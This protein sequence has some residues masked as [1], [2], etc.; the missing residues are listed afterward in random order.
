MKVLG[1]EQLQ[2]IKTINKGA[3]AIESLLK[4]IKP[5]GETSKAI[6]ALEA[7]RA[8]FTG[9]WKTFTFLMG[10]E[11]AK[12]YSRRMLFNPKAQNTAKKLIDAAKNNAPER[13]AILAQE[14]IE[15][16]EVGDDNPANK[17]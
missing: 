9:S 5:A 10:V 11:A 12:V 1:P 4:Q 17:R 7:A 6:R 8:F 3:D 14:L 15:E 13:A 2:N 16:S